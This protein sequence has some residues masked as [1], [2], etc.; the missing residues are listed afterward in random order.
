MVDPVAARGVR[1]MPVRGIDGAGGIEERGLRGCRGGR[2]GSVKE[3]R[4]IIKTGRWIT[5]NHLLI[6]TG[7]ADTTGRIQVFFFHS[8]YIRLLLQYTVGS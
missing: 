7:L 1:G 4:V 6:R 5:F 8:F 3:E 2:W